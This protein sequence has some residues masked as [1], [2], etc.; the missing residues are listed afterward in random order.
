MKF[1]LDGM[2]NWEIV[3]AA[4]LLMAA[5]RFGMDLSGYGE[6]AFSPNSGNI[7]LWVE[8]YPFTLY[9]PI[10]SELKDADVWVQWNGPDDNEEHE[11][12]LDEFLDLEEI[13]AWIKKLEELK[14]C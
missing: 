5:D 1:D 12:T 13:Y 14:Q 3:K 10:S 6:V 2:R 9:L 8:D 11:R 7:F 4:Y